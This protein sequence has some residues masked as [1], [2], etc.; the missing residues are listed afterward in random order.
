M[1]YEVMMGEDEL[2]IFSEVLEQREYNKV[3]ETVSK[4]TI[5]PIG[6]Y[7]GKV[8]EMFKMPT[9]EEEARQIAEVLKR[10]S[11]ARQLKREQD[12]IS[13]QAMLKRWTG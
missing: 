12:V 5:K 1:I 9:Q 10:K 8:K 4:K 2:R 3:L 6:R 11:L 13:G 7:L